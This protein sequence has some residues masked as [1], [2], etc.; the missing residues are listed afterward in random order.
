[1]DC[2]EIF[3]IKDNALD[4]SSFMK[5]I[6]DRGDDQDYYNKEEDID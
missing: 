6:S 2:L 4:E 3:P 1:L 5:S